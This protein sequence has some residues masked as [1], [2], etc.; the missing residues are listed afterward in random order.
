MSV[1]AHTG[2]SIFLCSVSSL[3]TMSIPFEER[4]VSV[5]LRLVSHRHLLTKLLRGMP[6][7]LSFRIY[8]MGLCTDPLPV[9]QGLNE[10]ACER[11]L[12]PKRAGQRLANS[13]GKEPD[14]KYFRLCGTS[15]VCPRY[16]TLLLQLERGRRRTTNEWVWL[17]PN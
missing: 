13:L 1:C 10:T 12:C 14:S 6:L 2:S 4:S 8:K 7:K 17:C 11:I 15:D 3:G 9:S 16:S 5:Y